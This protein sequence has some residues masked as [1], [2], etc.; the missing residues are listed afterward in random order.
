[1]MSVPIVT[2]HQISRELISWTRKARI[3]IHEEISANVE[4]FF[5]FRPEFVP[6]WT[7]ISADSTF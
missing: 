1:M 5:Q 4:T 7:G 6:G 3:A 2:C